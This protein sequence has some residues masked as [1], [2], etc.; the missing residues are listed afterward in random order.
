[1]QIERENYILL[2]SDEPQKA[3][4]ETFE[5]MGEFFALLAEE[6]LRQNAVRG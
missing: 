5:I 3:T 6:Q 4:K 1:M 2:I